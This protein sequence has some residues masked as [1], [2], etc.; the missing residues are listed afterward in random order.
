MSNL[1]A[2]DKIA[3]GDPETGKWQAASGGWRGV[4]FLVHGYPLAN[5]MPQCR[6][7]ALI[8]VDEEN[9]VAAREFKRGVALV[10]IIVKR[11][12]FNPCP[13]LAH[14]INRAIGAARI[15]DNEFIG[16]S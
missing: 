14:N 4:Q 12:I 8:R 6:R 9:P 15:Q 3:A 1:F 5:F 11:A 16:K 2:E 13:R 7:R 10:R